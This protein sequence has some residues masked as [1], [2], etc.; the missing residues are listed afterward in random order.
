MMNKLTFKYIFKWNDGHKHS[1]QLELDSETISIIQ[2]IPEQTPDW[3][4]LDFHQCPNCPLHAEQSPNCPMA[5]HLVE[6]CKLFSDLTSHEELQLIVT[7]N[8]R[9]TIKNTTAQRAISS[10]LGLIIPASGC[11][12]TKFFRPMA[13]F[14]LPLSSEDETIFRATGMYLLAQY[15]LNQDK[16]KI[17]LELKGLSDIYQQ[18]HTVN[19]YIAE[20][21]REAFSN[22]STVNAVI[23]LD[24]FAKT[25]PYAIDESLE[26][27]KYL[28]QPYFA[29]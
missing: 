14:H 11:P 9:S 22:D 26:E 7:T 21:F 25:M 29:D 8:E 17:D 5:Y 15:F 19:H 6:A 23:L 3:A 16:H 27:I 18:L 4:R 12:H 24:I 20:R 2:P 28:F 10:L 1:Y 13:R